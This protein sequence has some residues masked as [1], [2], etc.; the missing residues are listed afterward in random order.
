LNSI[1]T[2]DCLF[3][4][5]VEKVWIDKGTFVHDWEP[6]FLIKTAN[7]SMQKVELGVSGTISMVNVT[8][9]DRV[10]PHLTLAVIEEDRLPAACD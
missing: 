6:L 8:Q 10:C 9:G 4:G 1:R 7:G 2:I 3:D 5:I